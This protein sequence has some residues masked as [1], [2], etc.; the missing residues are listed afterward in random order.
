[1]IAAGIES[2]TGHRPEMADLFEIAE[3]IQPDSSAKLA[4]LLK[5]A[6]P[7]SLTAAAL[8]GPDDWT[9]EELEASQRAELD[10]GS[11]QKKLQA[12]Q[13]HREQE[14]LEIMGLW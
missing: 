13:H 3:A 10:I 2:R 9:V 5:I 14:F 7:P 8:L 12:Q 1:V 4:A 11:E 6:K